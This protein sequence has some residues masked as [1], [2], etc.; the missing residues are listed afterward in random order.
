MSDPLRYRIGP[1]DRIVAVDPQFEVFARANGAPG[2]V[3]SV[4]GTLLWE[5]LSGAG[6]VAIH[7]QFLER[8]RDDARTIRMPFRCDAPDRRRFMSLAIGPGED[9]GTVQFEA[10]LLRSKPRDRV[11]LWDVGA[12]RDEE[13]ALPACA[14][15]KRVKVEET[16]IDAETASARLRL[17]ERALVP[18]VTHGVCGECALRMEG[19]L[20][21]D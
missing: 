6:V 10:R 14:W 7:R 11:T 12:S 17:S 21:T 16:W 8:V 2:L 18:D 13:R 1:D 3:H 4:I 15:C 9:S 20:K 5:H 19:L